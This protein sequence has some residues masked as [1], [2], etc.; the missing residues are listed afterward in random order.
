MLDKMSFSKMMLGLGEL[1]DK[2]ITEFVADMYY[3]ILKNYDYPQVEVAIK[4]VIATHKYNTLPKPA[5]I[6]EYLE[7]SPSDKSLIAW[8]KAKEAVS[9]G[10]YVASIEFDD[11]I[12]SHCLES[13]GGWQWFCDV[14]IDELPFVE[15]RFRDLYN[16]LRKR[17]IALPIKLV[18][19]IE[20]KNSERGFMDKIPEPVKIGFKEKLGIADKRG[21]GK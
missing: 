16:T 14:P 4:K 12:I 9:K 20:N 18:G 15:K 8:L 5:D 11:P 6:L 1:Y 19:F 17:D 21:V 13:L 3:D 10:G 2:Q 7:G